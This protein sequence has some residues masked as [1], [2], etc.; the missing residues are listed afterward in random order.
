MVH[1][2]RLSRQLLI[3]PLIAVALVSIG[4]PP[5]TVS[6]QQPVTVQLSPQN[7][8]GITGTA[9]LT[10]MGDQTRVILT[11]TGAGAGPEPAHIHEGTC[12]NLDPTPKWP[13]TSVANGTSDTMVNAKLSDIQ[14]SATAINVHKSP[15]EISVYVACGNIPMAGTTTGAAPA[16]AAAQAAGVAATP[17]PAAA[18]A[19]PAASAPAAAPAAAPPAQPTRPPAQLPKTGENEFELYGLLAIGVL[20]L[21]AGTGSMIHRRWI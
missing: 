18:P 4:A 11:L 12:A 1:A 14:A 3:V 13:L 21:V 7:N 6:A 17:A 9:T 19:V 10:S 2:M 16:P 8:S 20:L 5:D 15:Q